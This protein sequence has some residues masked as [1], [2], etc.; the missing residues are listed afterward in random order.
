MHVFSAVSAPT[1]PHARNVT[2]R[3]AVVA[4]QAERGNEHV[5][6][7]GAAQWNQITSHRCR[8]WWTTPLAVPV[9]PT[10]PG[11]ETSAPRPIGADKQ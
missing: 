8:Q 7:T 6:S 9:L 5:I 10:T 4:L 2:F 11:Q 1:R 3:Q